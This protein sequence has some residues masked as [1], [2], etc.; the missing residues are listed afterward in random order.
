[1]IEFSHGIRAI[2]RDRKGKSIMGRDHDA[3]LHIFSENCT[4]E[5]DFDFSML[6]SRLEEEVACVTSSASSKVWYIDSG[7]S[8]HM[9][10]IRECFSDY[11]EEKMNFNITMGNKAK[12]TPVG[13][14][15]I[16]FQTET[17]VVPCYQCAACT[18]IGDELTF[19]VETLRQRI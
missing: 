1:M 3:D 17:R 14:G 15:T 8:W 19:R 2:I 4:R 7:A 18:R 16:V 5:S 13:R 9:M 12:C 10:G 6:A 11:R